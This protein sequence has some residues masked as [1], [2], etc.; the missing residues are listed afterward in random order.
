[1]ISPLQ[2]VYRILFDKFG[3]QGWWQLSDC[4]YHYGDYN[5]PHNEKQIYEIIVG[6]ILAQNSKWDKCYAAI[7]QLRMHSLLSPNIILSHEILEHIKIA[8][9][10]NKKLQYIKNVTQFYIDLNGSIPS[11]ESLLNVVGIGEETADYILLYGYKV[12]TIPITTEVRKLL[13]WPTGNKKANKITRE[14]IM[15]SLEYKLDTYQE[16]A[17][18]ALRCIRAKE[19]IYEIRSEIQKILN[20]N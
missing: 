10:H 11:R 4:G 20:E 13:Y 14:Y 6:S 16:F 18:L 1:M 17:P 12:M 5:Y 19:D 7:Q 3:P 9:T 2:K 15:A 8:G